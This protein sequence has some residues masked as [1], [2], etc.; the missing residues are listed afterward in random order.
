MSSPNSW[1][2][3]SNFSGKPSRR[4]RRAG[5]K[6]KPTTS[7]RVTQ[8]EDRTTPA[9]GSPPGLFGN[10]AT[11]S[12]TATGPYSLVTADLN[13]DGI[14]DLVTANLGGDLSFFSGKGNGLF[15]SPTSVIV[16]GTQPFSVVTAD[17]NGDTKPDLAVAL[18]GSNQVAILPGN[19]NGTFLAGQLINVG[20]GP[21][22]IRTA[23]LNNDSKPDLVTANSTGNSVSVLLNTG[24]GFSQA[25][26]VPY[27]VPGQDPF[28]VAVADYTGDGKPDLAVANNTSNDIV[29]LTNNG[30]G[31][32]TPFATTIPAPGGSASPFDIVAGNFDGA[33]GADLAVS[34]GANDTV[35]IFT[36]NNNGTFVAKG[37][38]STGA[39]GASP[40]RL[41]TGDFN[42]DGKL[43]L[44]V[45][46]AGVIGGQVGVL[47]GNGDGTLQAV[48]KFVTGGNGS[49]APAV[50]DFNVDGKPDLAVANANGNSVGVL[51]NTYVVPATL[52][53]TVS[54]T[55][56]TLTVADTDTTGKANNL[57][58]TSDGTFITITDPTE[59]FTGGSHSYKI[60]LAGLTSI[61]INGA[62]GN[63][64]LT[65]DYSNGT[66]PNISF[67]GGAGGNDKLSVKGNGTTSATY[68]AAATSTATNHQGTIQVGSS[69]ISF[70]NI[71]PI[72]IS[73]MATASLAT[74]PPPATPL[75]AN[76]V[77]TI[78]NGFDLTGPGTTPA[79]VVS[80]TTAG[81]PIE[82]VAFF[83]NMTVIID[84]SG[85]AA[86]ADTFTV[87]G[88]NGT[89][90]GITNLTL[91]T[92][93]NSGDAITVNG[94]TTFSGT[95]TLNAP[96]INLNANVTN[97]ITGTTATT[98]NVTAPGQIQDGVN[99]AA[100]GAT[101][102]VAA[103]TYIESVSVPKTL[104]LKGAK[105]GVDAR[106]RTGAETII[107]NST[108][109]G[110]T[111]LYVT[112]SNVSID[113]FTLQG[114]TSSNQFGPAIFLA[115]T[116][117][118][119]HVVNNI[120]QNNYAG[121]FL[122]NSNAINQGVVQYNLFQ[123]NNGGLN[124]D[125]Y[126][127]QFTAGVGGVKNV[128]IDSNTFTNSAPVESSWALGIS[129]TNATAFT[130][131]TFSNN[132]VTNHGR[133]VYFYN[134]TGIAVTGN[135][136]LNLVGAH[137]AIGF[138][139]GNSTITVQGNRIDGGSDGIQ[140]ADDFGTPNSGIT[141]TQN[142]FKNLSRA[143][144]EFINEGGTAYTGTLD[145]SGN[146]WGTSKPVAVTASIIQDAGPVSVVDFTPLLDNDE[147]VA[148]QSVVG[149]Q[150]DL[151]SA[152]V[153]SLGAQSGTTGR[154]QEGVNLIAGSLTSAN[155]VLNVTAGTYTE[156]V[157]TAATSVTLAPG[158]SPGLVTLNGNLTL[159]SNDTL[160]VEL[161]GT[162][163]GTQYDQLFVNGTVNLGGAALSVSQFAAFT[164]NPTVTQSFT[165]I[166]ND[167]T[168]AVTGIFAGLPEGTPITYA[169][170]TVYVS[171]HGG[172]GNDVVLY[173]TPVV[174]GTT[175]DDTF[176]FRKAAAPAG[177]YEISINGG[178][179]VNLG[180]ITTLAVNGLDG[181]DTLTID[182]TNA[183]ALLP[184]GITFNGG[185]PT[186]TPGD[187]LQVLAGA[188]TTI[189]NSFTNANDG[190]IDFDGRKVF[191]T[192]LEPVLLNVG[193]V[194]DVIFN[195]PASPSSSAV[196]G[197]DGTLGNGRLRLASSPVNFET[198]DFTAPT[199]SLT[200]NRGNVADS[201]NTLDLSDFVATASLNVGSSGS[202]FSTFNITGKATAAAV[203]VFA[204]AIG[205]DATANL[206]VTGTASFTGNVVIA[207]G[208]V[209][210]DSFNFGSLTFNSTS[211]VTVVEDSQTDLVGSSTAGTL[212]LT[213]AGLLTNVNNATLS[214]GGNANLGGTSISLGNQATDTV[215]FASLTFN[216]AGAVSISEDSDTSLAGT[217]TAAS[218][219]LAS[220]AG[221]TNATN[222]S[223]TVTGTASFNGTSV[224]LGNQT[225]DTMN[226][227]D[228]TVSSTGAVSV[229]ENTATAVNTVSGTTIT[230]SSAG[231]ITDNNGTGTNNLTGTMV[232]LSAAGGIDL[233]T[234]IAS[235]TAT[236]SAA[237]SILIRE[238]DGITLTNMTSSNGLI[239]ITAGG[240]ITATNVVSST[241][242]DAND[243][244]ITAT[245]G[246]NIVVGTINAGATAGDVT[247]SAN[248]GTGSILNSGT[249][250]VTGDVVTLTAAVDIGT[251]PPVVNINTAANTII[252]STTASPNSGTHGIWINET[253]GV[254]LQN[255]T[256]QDGLIRII[257]GGST[258]A[259][260]VVAA[261]AARNVTI[262]NT[263]G[264][265]TA[266]VVTASNGN[267][268]LTSTLGAILDGNAAG[269]TNV[270]AGAATG[271]GTFT[272]GTTVNLDT[273]LVNLALS[274]PNGN[275][276]IREFD[277]LNI[278]SA[279]V[280]ASVFE[281]STAGTATQSGTI[282]AGGFR[283]TGSGVATLAN[284]A[285]DVA[286]L[287]ANRTGDFTYVDANSLTI[288][289][290]TGLTGSTSGIALGTSSLVVTALSG[291]LVVN[292]AVTTS[293]TI[294]VS[295]VDATAATL[296]VNAAISGGSTVGLATGAG[297]DAVTV[298][299]TGSVTG[300][301]MVMISGNAGNDTFTL[302][303]PVSGPNAYVLGGDGT[304]L[305]AVT[306]SGASTLHLDGQ[307]NAD[308]YTITVGT[309][310]GTVAVEE[311]GATGTDTLTVQGTAAVDTYDVN[312][313][314]A[315]N[316][317]VRVTGAGVS[318]P[319]DTVT[320]N[321]GVDV[322]NLDAQGGDDVYN[323]QFTTGGLSFLPPVTNIT[324]TGASA[325]D[326]A[327][328][329]GTDNPDTIDVNFSAVRT[330][331]SGGETITYANGNLDK[332]Y[333]FSKNGNDT[334]STR[335]VAK[336][337]GGPEVHLD[338]GNPQSP[339]ALP[340]DFLVVD[341]AGVT[342][343][344]TATIATPNGSLP[345]TSHNLLDWVSFET[346]P[347][348]IGLGG[349]FDF[350]P[351][352]G[353]VQ[354]GPYAP[355]WT[356][357]ANTDV[358]PTAGYYGWASPV[359]AADRGP[360]APDPA[361]TNFQSVLRDSNWFGPLNVA[362]TFSVATIAKGNY[363]VS[364]TLG[365]HDVVIDNVFVTIEGAGKIAVPTV[366][367]NQFVTLTAVGSDVNGDGKIDVTFV[368]TFGTH[369]Y[370]HVN[371]VDVRPVNLVSP[372]TI[373][374]IDPMSKAVI[375]NS[376]LAAD[377]LSTTT[378]QAAG[379]FPNAVVSIAATAGTLSGV[380]PDGLTNAADADPFLTGLQVRTD[381]NGVAY[382]RL[383]APTGNAPVTLTANA[384]I[385]VDA[386]G[387]YTQAY[388]L[389]TARKVDFNAAGSTGPTAAGYL[390]VPA[391]LYTN[392]AGNGLGWLEP[393][394]SKDRGAGF[395]GALFE[396]FNYG[397]IGSPGVLAIDVP[398][399]AQQVVT[400]YIGDLDAPPDEMVI[401]YFNGTAFV[402]LAANVKAAKTNIL[403][404]TVTPVD[405]G[406]GNF[407][408]R[409]RISDA[410]GPQ[411][412]WKLQ[413]L[414][415]RPL[416]TQGV[417]AVS[418]T[419]AVAGDGSLITTY[420]ISGGPATGLVTI[421]T[422]YGAITTAD[423]SPDYD[424]VQVLLT[425]GTGS[426]AIKS[427]VVAAGNVNSS[428]GLVAVDGAFAGGFT[429]VYTGAKVSY[430]FGPA[431]SPVAANF[432]GVSATE[433][434]SNQTGYGFAVA[435][436][437]FDRLPADYPQ[438]TATGTPDF[439]RD[440]ANGNP[441]AV[442][443]VLVQPG[444]TG[445]PVTLY[446]FD[447]YSSRGNVTVTVEGGGTQTLLTN[448]NGPVIFNLTGGDANNDGVL[449]VTISAF[450]FWTA[451]G[452]EIG[453]SPPVLPLHAA[454]GPVAAGTALSGDALA[455]LTAEAVRR[456]SMLDLTPAQRA[457][458]GAVTVTTADLDPAGEL[459][460]ASGTRVTI[461]D[462]ANGA[463]WYV[464]PTP[465][466]DAEY[467]VNGADL[468]GTGAAAGRFDLL[469]VLEHEIGHALGLQHTASGLMAEA[470]PPGVRRLP[471]LPAD[472]DLVELVVAP[473]DFAVLPTADGSLD[474]GAVKAYTLS[475]ASLS[476][477]SSVVLFGVAVDV[478]QRPA[479]KPST[480][481]PPA[482]AY[483]VTTE[484]EIGSDE[485][486]DV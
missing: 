91:N 42:L 66:L 405:I 291:S 54:G 107:D 307:A 27:T 38:F 105:A 352:G 108:N 83:N 153:H 369:E 310:D 401:E 226:F 254:T 165:I 436:S 428:V 322:M 457:A 102:N 59:V 390:G 73:G 385:V 236:T 299:A 64:T 308:T 160:A 481:S 201:L 478:S 249:N 205:N 12:T 281:L 43:D 215:N 394:L 486:N 84:T 250:L 232:T 341:V 455:A 272:A 429:Q 180:A 237:G 28:S 149:F 238:A 26:T 482:G 211:A 415:Y 235:L 218:L 479:E 462:D 155:R 121:L 10:V 256:T 221:I 246:G 214:V 458:L 33:G 78:A 354:A 110:K 60:A 302:N 468:T 467:V 158:S 357:V 183:N 123:N 216:S 113:G 44:A 85:I 304:D 465:G 103:G 207:L 151:S 393:V 125:I 29:I 4:Q 82:S 386:K 229:S 135:D 40:E 177:T 381:A 133:G 147:S 171:Y 41:A 473:P 420:G 62:G 347:V 57:T 388:A 16:G 323:L 19:G 266:N 315:G 407:Q 17:F 277:G 368:D 294:A 233:D 248:T 264:D 22:T 293:G 198:T 396:D 178:V 314:A 404:F 143:S 142:A 234:T 480:T 80:G 471:V 136:F 330:T 8:L 268:T 131:I 197:D 370:W 204:S 424:G 88:A 176:V 63:D 253:D 187:K 124:T 348:P 340:G 169:G 271:L 122:T 144:I 75:A 174:N 258:T 94:T 466:D 79:I 260:S 278:N 46:N 280:G 31:A 409:F 199:G 92:G 470:L 245:G 324:D 453:T 295:A 97:A 329:Y 114:S 72:D 58:V 115:P 460:Q 450:S 96:T 485:F 48:Q 21:F 76:N 223:L 51:L 410:G 444:L 305:F 483:R 400:L 346:I 378:Y 412:G 289:T 99:V 127:D 279:N 274:S 192:G 90:A 447:A 333:V 95:T 130:N 377:G 213:S 37:S 117:S 23:D 350:G 189:T 276:A 286:A 454:A 7:L 343:L 372:V 336:A 311:S 6:Q 188:Y 150:A 273:R 301:G 106:A 231:A 77:F 170:G 9:V 328:V 374:R 162:T 263:A 435:A 332:L 334:V 349:T 359:N 104:T 477:P 434:F 219:T 53:P 306:K 399:G 67:D 382:F 353:A 287:A 69:L 422:K 284:T 371:A 242:S 86:S 50:G 203:T 173:S 206:N 446:A 383:L 257:T 181:N 437:D 418:P 161:G 472:D 358:Y 71:E 321:N 185:N 433:V 376:T 335:P 167:G 337:G 419:A 445:I 11:S 255:V 313:A 351:A 398:S 425:G 184:A 190:R 282:T 342:G 172:D 406:G 484:P 265:L 164:V 241:D 402:P 154:I 456:W 449:D 132:S 209:P 32:F 168:D 166:D 319:A 331:K 224:D 74:L 283:F 362:G 426:F 202:P 440:G 212:T 1:R 451:N 423:A 363:Q 182:N 195:L 163:A 366:F 65:L 109:A 87:S 89:A 303:G 373:D 469:T 129:N 325:N 193:S 259:T 309:L 441:P 30:S 421:S 318:S 56:D 98:V 461:D 5:G 34:Y 361:Q 261:G 269:T 431:G 464:D 262:N 243:I 438:I 191:Y 285:N 118:G 225:G 414:E 137:Y 448:T 227:G 68:S 217:S 18:R 116:T 36:G 476:G 442:Y 120:I 179:F 152:T 141:A 463:G 25:S 15:N 298:S 416:S 159:D 474:A 356:G 417:L 327:N 439:Y 45:A 252:A 247:L 384:A 200:I 345:S 288:D 320:Y 138:F 2:N 338:G 24:T 186:S 413:G 134:T 111:A 296:T 475:P 367:Q 157:T 317:T 61:V 126:A 3:V 52:T 379:F 208:N 251:A 292:Q 397:L 220:T 239:T 408:M 156:N 326:V 380:A 194:T 81:N 119:A 297:N 244:S 300:T 459:G 389:P 93:A 290:V 344:D 403:S 228:L 411:N 270:T 443:K 14:L 128:L 355:Y 365:D 55:G 430:D 392:S 364:V 275:A 316:A 47:L 100:T 230:L 432:K 196:L 360:T 452:I 395:G 210:G 240:T 267:V 145:A 13:N 312:T 35:S 39:S 339:T 49:I 148:N 146:Y 20:S 112:A 222:A 101:V 139:N 391:T 175:G 427:P 70:S 387:T 140:I 375:A